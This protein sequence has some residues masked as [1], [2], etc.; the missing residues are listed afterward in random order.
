MTDRKPLL[1]EGG[2]SAWPVQI[3]I[4]PRRD[5]E[6]LKVRKKLKEKLGREPTPYEIY[7]DIKKKI[8]L[9][10]V[11]DSL[12]RLDNYS[13]INKYVQEVGRTGWFKTQAAERLPNLAQLTREPLEKAWRDGYYIG[14]V[15]PFGWNKIAPR[16]MEKESNMIWDLERHP[17]EFPVVKEIIEDYYLHGEGTEQIRG[18]L[19]RRNI[20]MEGYSI[21]DILFRN[22][23]LYAG[24]VKYAGKW[25]VGRHK[26]KAVVGDEFWRTYIQPRQEAPKPEYLKGRRTITG[27]VRKFDEWVHDPTQIEVVVEKSPVAVQVRKSTVEAEVYTALKMRREGAGDGAISRET[28][29]HKG[30]L[31][32]MFRDP[33][34]ANKIRV[35]DKP[36]DEWPDAGVKPYISFKDW[37]EIQKIHDNR[38]FWLIGKEFGK[39][40]REAGELKITTFLREHGKASTSE[41]AKGTGFSNVSAL[42]YLHGSLKEKVGKEPKWFGKWY[43]FEK[44][45]DLEIDQTAPTKDKILAALVEPA[46]LDE[47]P[48]K[49]GVSRDQAKYWL[50][51]LIT[52]GLVEKRRESGKRYPV[53]VKV[54]PQQKVE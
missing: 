12:R 36:P 27:F 52:Q 17:E 15:R 35:P 40:R 3:T 14:A 1:T 2:H 42:A 46:S 4:R 18:K 50:P 23:R 37:V 16:D 30:T 33:T 24:Y 7:K 53:Y 9:N 13:W 34:Y 10:R 49:A 5:L 31:R 20:R 39:N 41:I 8:P 28:G 45:K 32:N 19:L 26:S 25:G 6:I 21:R 43:L 44:A 48:E 51:K 38:P 47:I 54:S 22:I 11:K 29:F